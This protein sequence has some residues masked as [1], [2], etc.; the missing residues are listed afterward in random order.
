MTFLINTITTH[1]NTV[2][3]T[4]TQCNALQHSAAHCNN[5]ELSTQ[6]RISKKT[7][8]HCP[9]LQH[10]ST[11][12][13]TRCNMLQKTAASCITLHHTA[14]HYS[15]LQHTAAHCNTLQQAYL[16]GAVLVTD[17]IFR[18][19][20]CRGSWHKPNFVVNVFNVWFFVLWYLY[21]N[22]N[23][24]FTILFSLQKQFQSSIGLA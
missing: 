16:R 18:K 20:M 23:V 7:A 21:W 14:T 10:T 24:V 11:H 8:T 19:G 15:T 13:S 1:C 4:A 3:H 17:S 12:T 9:T 5:H 22:R 2:K 6:L